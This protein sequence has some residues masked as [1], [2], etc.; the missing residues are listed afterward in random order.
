MA[1]VPQVTTRNVLVYSTAPVSLFSSTTNNA[2]AKPSR[3]EK[4]VLKFSSKKIDYSNLFCY[5]ILFCA[6]Q[7]YYVL[8]CFLHSILLKGSIPYYSGLF[9]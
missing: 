7:R 9:L 1:A 3:I 4:H 2:N 6:F 8:L 5:Y